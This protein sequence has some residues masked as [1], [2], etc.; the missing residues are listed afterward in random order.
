MELQRKALPVEWKIDTDSEDKPTGRVKALVAV[1]DNVDYGDDRIKAGAFTDSIAELAGK[2]TGAT[3]M[4][5]VF[6]HSWGDLD[7][8]IGVVESAKE[9]D[10][11]LEVEA[12]LWLDDPAAAKAFRLLQ[13]GAVKE[14]SFGYQAKEFTWVKEDDHPYEIRELTKV[15]IFECGPCLKGMN[16]ATQLLEAASQTVTKRP[17]KTEQPA[18]GDSP[19]TIETERVVDLLTRPRYTEA[20]Q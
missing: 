12:Q 15:D 3:L 14:F 10:Q 2:A 5:F 6:S 4:P 18:P 20:A 19:A 1:F 8:F 7:A 11:G 16:P 9:T 13:S 17:T